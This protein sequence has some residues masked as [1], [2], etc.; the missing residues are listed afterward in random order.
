[1]ASARAPERGDLVW[2]S[3]D[4]EAGHEQAGRRPAVVISP[5]SYNEK[6]GLALLC[7]VTSA[8]RGHPCEV[9][10]PAGLPV[11]GAILCDQIKSLD[12]SARKAEVI[13]RLPDDL[14]AHMPARIRTL[15]E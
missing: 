11:A 13:R 7:L 10:G 14:I 4:P 9:G 6:V 2:L 1:M 3:F 15:T 12:W 5:R 8:R